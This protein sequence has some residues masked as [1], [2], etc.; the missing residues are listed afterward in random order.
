MSWH[1]VC[2][3]SMGICGTLFLTAVRFPFLCVQ[4]ELKLENKGSR[5]V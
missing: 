1:D 5:R 3:C 2:V 4:L